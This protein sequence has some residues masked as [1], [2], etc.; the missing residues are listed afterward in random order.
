MI[1][2]YIYRA[3]GNYLDPLMPGATVPLS[4]GGGGG[5]TP[6]FKSSATTTITAGTAA[7]S[8]VCP[9][10]VVTGD[11]LL[12]ATSTAY[13]TTTVTWPAGWTE[14]TPAPTSSGNNS[15]VAW[16]TSDGTE[17]GT[18]ITATV[19]NTSKRPMIVAVYSG[20]GGT[21]IAAQAS[22]VQ[23]TATTSHPTPALTS[24]GANQLEVALGADATGNGATQTT[25]WTFPGLTVRASSISTPAGAA[26]SLSLADS[27][28]AV[29]AAGASLG[30][31]A[32]TTDVAAVGTSWTILLA[33]S[34][35]AVASTNPALY[36]RSGTSTVPARLGIRTGTTITYL[37]PAVTAPTPPPPATNADW[38]ASPL[39]RPD[40][41]TVAFG[42][43]PVV[44]T[45]A[46]VNA[47][48]KRPI[49]L[50][51]IYATTIP[52]LPAFLARCQ[53]SLNAGIVPVIDFNSP[54]TYA[55][56]GFPMTNV[57]GTGQT[58]WAA[59]GSGYFDA[60]QSAATSFTGQA[61]PGFDAFLLGMKNLTAGACPTNRVI[62]SKDHEMESPTEGGGDGK[63]VGAAAAVAAGTQPEFRAAWRHFAA[64]MRA[65]NVTN[66]LL[67][68]NFA[69]ATTR[70]GTAMT[71]IGSDGFYPGHDCVDIV[72]WDPYNSAG[73]RDTV[74]REFS[75]MLNKFG[76][77]D[78]WHA[79][80]ALDGAAT[81]AAS[82]NGRV[83][84]P[85]GLFEFGTTDSYT[86][87]D[88]VL[89][90]A[91]TWATNMQTYMQDPAVNG[92][93]RWLIYFNNSINTIL[94][95]PSYRYTGFSNV[96]RGA[97]WA[98]NDPL[99]P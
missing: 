21:P 19:S 69:S 72:A 50:Q 82:T 9:S 94:T 7:P 40:A 78:W 1:A 89:H 34:G 36:A 31:R 58:M 61:Y 86:G 70:W 24:T 85:A 71:D 92:V 5:A 95:N 6:V 48:W 44:G 80:F 54:A 79:N 93:L 75:N 52:D 17:G 60:S 10:G 37:S 27:A 23:S 22:A 91:E 59:Q 65:L 30:G 97:V 46:D 81:L 96:G 49:R 51:R 26:A 68:F 41:G 14:L 88:N 42:V 74:W 84:K 12:L 38:R 66:V 73:V 2:A 45:V 99:L 76:Q 29:N 90:T 4:G 18:T 32:V 87:T 16:R 11:L 63:V 20:V 64:R 43:A 13:G 57:A 39:L 8:V 53:A 35:A 33:P 55:A 62:L 3:A 47:I 67:A 83:Y 56:S 98:G 77:L 28:A 15:R 25:A